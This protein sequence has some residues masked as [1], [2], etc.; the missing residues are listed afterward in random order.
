M[1]KNNIN[2]L[3]LNNY[4]KNEIKKL[5]NMFKIKQI[6][7]NIKQIHIN[8]INN[9][10]SNSIRIKYRHTNLYTLKLQMV[11]QTYNN[12]IFLN[13]IIKIGITKIGI[14]KTEKRNNDKY[15]GLILNQKY[16]SNKYFNIY[17]YGKL[18]YKESKLIKTK[19]SIINNIYMIID[20]NYKNKEIE[21]D[22]WDEFLKFYKTQLKELDLTDEC[23]LSINQSQL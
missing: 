22:Q 19:Y 17:D 5:K 16:L 21:K 14:I 15:L 2:L 8:N 10:I 11:N 23:D 18:C 9:S 4:V 6:K 1:K 7:Q 3:E 20:K 12:Y 13:G